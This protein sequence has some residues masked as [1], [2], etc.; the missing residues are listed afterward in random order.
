MMRKI[1]DL[2]VDTALIFAFKSLRS[3]ANRH[4]YAHIP[5]GKWGKYLRKRREG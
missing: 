3:E 5:F 2:N 1:H 4:R